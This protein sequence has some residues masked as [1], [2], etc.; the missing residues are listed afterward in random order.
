VA[1]AHYFNAGDSSEAAFFNKYM[2]ML[3]MVSVPVLILITY[4][5][6]FVGLQH[7]RDRCLSVVYIFGVITDRG[8]DQSA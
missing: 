2:V 8:A 3:L 5:L 1:L 7:G 4:A 6:L